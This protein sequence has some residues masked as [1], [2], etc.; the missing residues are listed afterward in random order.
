MNLLQFSLLGRIVLSQLVDVVGVGD[1]AAWRSD[2]G[3]DQQ[4]VQVALPRTHPQ[5]LL[6]T[7]KSA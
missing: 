7:I 3:R 5:C 1:N 6:A 2:C 4:V